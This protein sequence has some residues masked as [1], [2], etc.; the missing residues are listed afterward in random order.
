MGVWACGCVRF[1]FFFFCLIVFFFFLRKF[2]KS[3]NTVPK[4]LSGNRSQLLS[5]ELKNKNLQTKKTK[6][7]KQKTEKK[8]EKKLNNSEKAENQNTKKQKLQDIILL[9]RAKVETTPPPQPFLSLSS[10]SSS[11]LSSPSLPPPPNPLFDVMGRWTLF[12]VYGLEPT[13]MV[14]CR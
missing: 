13:E 11:H 14:T 8:T 12:S 9:S 6:K 7:L 3:K 1:F 5:K 10:P 2:Q 4:L